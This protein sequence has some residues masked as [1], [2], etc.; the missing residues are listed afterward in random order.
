VS[1]AGA[2]EE[3][4]DACERDCGS[5]FTSCAGAHPEAAHGVPHTNLTRSVRV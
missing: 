5:D 3:D 1:S 4:D 2:P